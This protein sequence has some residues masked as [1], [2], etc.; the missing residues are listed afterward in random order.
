MIPTGCP[1]KYIMVKSDF[2]VKYI[3]VKY[4][5]T[6]STAKSI[7]YLILFAYLKC[8]ELPALW[9]LEIIKKI[10]PIGLPTPSIPMGSLGTLL[11][12]LLWNYLT[13]AH[14]SLML[15]H[16]KKV[17]SLNSPRHNFRTFFS[18]WHL[19]RVVN[20]KVL[21]SCLSC[22]LSSFLK[23]ITFKLQSLSY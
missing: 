8:P 23:I 7:E 2:K 20:C 4:I 18:F 9:I 6:K 21:T 17:K 16:E 13:S 22:Q 11:S 1:T 3:W 10:Y 5:S 14:D 19:V 15:S 12:F